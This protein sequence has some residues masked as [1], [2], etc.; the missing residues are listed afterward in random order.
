ME[1][2]TVAQARYLDWG[3]GRHKRIDLGARQPASGFSLSNEA[4]A[5]WTKIFAA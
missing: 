1:A 4:I 2:L 3:I 5:Y